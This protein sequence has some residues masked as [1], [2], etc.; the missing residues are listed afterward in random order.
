MEHLK[1]PE[2]LELGKWVG[3]DLKQTAREPLWRWVAQQ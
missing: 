3:I 1:N 2:C